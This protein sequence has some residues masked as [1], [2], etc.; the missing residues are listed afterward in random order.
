MKLS[1]C[2]ITYNHD[3]YI[4]RAVESVLAQETDFDFEIVIGE[5]CSTDGTRHILQEMSSANPGRL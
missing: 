3:A 2:M 1:V 4:R 5:D